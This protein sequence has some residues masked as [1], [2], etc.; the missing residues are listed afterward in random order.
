MTSR[1]SISRL[2]RKIYGLIAI[3]GLW[4]LLDFAV[5]SLVIPNPIMTLKYF[6]AH[7]T[8]EIGIHL[9]Y[10]FYRIVMAISISLLMGVLL[11]TVMGMTR[12]GDR[13]LSP[14]VYLGYPI[15][16]IAFLPVFMILFGLGDASKI[17]LIVSI[18]VFQ[19]MI[20][21][22][23]GIKEIPDEVYLSAKSLKLSYQSQFVHVV[24]PSILPKLISALRIGMGIAISALFFAENYA[25]QY[26][27]GYYIM[28][29]WIMVDYT[30]MFSGIIGISL[31]GYVIFTGIDF[32]EKK[33]CP[34]LN[35]DQ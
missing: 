31:M 20:G 19:I 21:V 29:N 32:L 35:A 13:I 10:S 4:T 34:W 23:D 33:L 15:P 28:N 24:F 12:W 16:K 8:N 27:I 14:I 25:T 30:A 7:F 26:G 18:I 22:R 5:D 9:V 17:G 1:Y 3:F 2:I 6:F 11:G